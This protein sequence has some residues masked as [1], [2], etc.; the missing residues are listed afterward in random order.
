MIRSSSLGALELEN[1][2]APEPSKVDSD[3]YVPG[4]GTRRLM[5]SSASVGNFAFEIFCPRN[6]ESCARTSYFGPGVQNRGR[7]PLGMLPNETAAFLSIVVG[8]GSGPYSLGPGPE[9]NGV[10]ANIGLVA[11]VNRPTPKLR[12]RSFTL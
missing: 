12:V 4:P 9:S 3:W 10:E 5:I 1:R 11:V 8:N 2:G 6:S 7:F